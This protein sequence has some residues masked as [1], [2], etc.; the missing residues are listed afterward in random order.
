MEG[1]AKPEV[2]GVVSVLVDHAWDGFAKT[3]GGCAFELCSGLMQNS[4]K[5][6]I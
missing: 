3:R 6:G 1:R 4:L 5:M 2:S